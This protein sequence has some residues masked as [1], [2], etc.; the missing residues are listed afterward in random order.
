LVAIDEVDELKHVVF[1][2]GAET[3]VLGQLLLHH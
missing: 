1:G 3:G 2:E